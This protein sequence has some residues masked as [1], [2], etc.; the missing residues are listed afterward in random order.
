ME[1]VLN[2]FQTFIH[3]KLGTE[4]D[5]PGSGSSDSPLNKRIEK[6]RDFSFRQK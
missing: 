1:V 3:V 6:L 4:Q 2:Y 5:K